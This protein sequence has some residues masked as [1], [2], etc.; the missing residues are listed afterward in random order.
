[1]R[2]RSFRSDAETDTSEKPKGKGHREGGR[3]TVITQGM[4][5]AV[6]RYNLYEFDEFDEFMNLMNLTIL[7][8]MMILMILI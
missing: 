2:R 8:N 5:T 1:M 3:W 4:G 7:M 6:I